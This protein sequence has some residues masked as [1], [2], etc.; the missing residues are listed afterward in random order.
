MLELGD[1]RWDFEAEIED[2][3][4]AL[5]ADVFGPFYH[6]REVAAGLDVLADAE[7]AGTFFEERILY[8]SELSKR[9]EISIRHLIR[10]E[11]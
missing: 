11:E 5:Q 1:R 10:I 3:L 2:F 6:A 8:K 9:L 4:L 7:V